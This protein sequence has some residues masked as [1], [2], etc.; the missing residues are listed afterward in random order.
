MS[1]GR[2]G[3]DEYGAR[4]QRKDE[5]PPNKTIKNYFSPVSKVID[6]SSPR[7]S[8]I[9]DYFIRSS[10]VIEKGSSPERTPRTDPNPQLPPTPL[11]T[12]SRASGRINKQAKRTQLIKKLNN[13]VTKAESDGDNPPG[14]AGFMGSDTAALLAEICSKA[15]D[16][17]DEAESQQSQAASNTGLSEGN[18]KRKHGAHPAKAAAEPSLHC[19][20]VL[21]DSTMNNSSIELHTDNTSSPSTISFEDFVRSQAEKDSVLS[22]SHGTSI[23]NT[24]LPQQTSPKTMTIQAQVHL[25]SLLASPT[26]VPAKIASIFCKKKMAEEQKKAD[27]TG[28]S[29]HVIQKR[30]SNVVIE[31]EDLELAVIDIEAIEPTKQKSTAAERQQF[32]KAFRQAGENPKNLAKKCAGKKKDLNTNTTEGTDD[33]KIQESGEKSPDKDGED[34][35]PAENKP[36]ES[37]KGQKLK[38]EL[39]KTKKIHSEKRLPVTER[40]AKP[41]SLEETSQPPQQSPVLRRSLR[42]HR[43][44]TTSGS[45]VPTTHESP[46]LMSTPKI[47]TPSRKNDIYKAEV[48]TVSSDLESPIRMRFT[49]LRR[50]ISDRQNA[51]ISDDEAFT[52][53]RKKVSSNNKKIDKA[54]QI[55]EKAKAIQ[56][57]IVKAET[58]QRRSAR[59]QKRLSQ[60]S[61]TKAPK[62]TPICQ[63]SKQPKQKNKAN[64]RSLND[65]LGKKE[66]AKISASSVLSL[67]TSEQ[68]SLRLTFMSLIIY[69]SSEASENSQDDE[70]FKAKREFLRSGLPDS[71]K[72]NIAKVAALKEAYALSSMSFHSVVHVQQKDGCEKWHM[73]MPH[74]PLLVKLVPVSL[75][76]PDVTSFTLSIGDFTSCSVPVTLQHFPGMLTRKA[77]F[78]EAVRNC[79]LEEIRWYNPQFPV[80]RFFTQFLKK[81]KDYLALQDNKPGGQQP[82]RNLRNKTAEEADNLAKRKRKD[83]PGLKSKKRKSDPTKDEPDEESAGKTRKQRL[84]RGSLRRS[85]PSRDPDVIVIEEEETPGPDAEGP[86]CEDVLWTE[87]YQPQSSSELIGNYVAIRSLHSW[88]RDW[89]ARAE[90]EERRT[91]KM[92]KDKNDTWDTDDFNEEDSDEDSLCNTMLI[93][94][95][96]GVGK[97]AAVYA[98]A[99]ELGFKVFEVNASC[100]RN[101]RQILAQL[102]EATQSHQVDQ[103]GVNAHKPCFFSSYSLGK[104]PRK[105]HSPKAVVS[106]PR[107]PPM[108]PRGGKKGLAPKS[109]A[110]FFKAAP[111]QKSEEKKTSLGHGKEKGTD[112]TQRKSATSLILFE[113]VDV[114]FDEDS[115]FLSAIKTFMS[116][117]KRPVILTT[118]DAM[119]GSMF[120]GVFEEITFHVP[121]VVN[122]ASYLQVLCLAENL[123][124]DTKDLMTFLTANTCDIRQSLLQLQFWAR[125]GGGGLKEKEL[126]PPAGK[127]GTLTSAAEED[128]GKSSIDVT[129]EMHPKELPECNFGCAENL[130]GLSSLVPPTEGLV[131]F[132][133]GRISKPE[134]LGRIMQ[135]LSEF[136]TRNQDL[137]FCNLENLLPL[138]LH[139]KESQAPVYESTEPAPSMEEEDVKM[140]AQMK[141]R[142]KLLLLND[143]DLFDSDSRSLDE[144]VFNKV[145]VDEPVDENQSYTHENPGKAVSHS[146]PLRR[147]LAGAELMASCL[148]YTC[149]DSMATF[150]DNLSYLDCCTC[151]AAEQAYAYNMN[152]TESRLRHGLCDSLRIDTA[153]PMIV[154]TAGEI[155]AYIEGLAFHKCSSALTKTLDTSLEQCRQ[156]GHDPTEQLTLQVSKSRQ[157]VNFSQ[158]STATATAEKRLSV[159][160]TVLSNRAFITLGNRQVNVTEYL[161][162]LRSI[163]RIEKAKEEGKTKRRFLHYLEGIH[164]E[165]PKTTV[166]SLATDFP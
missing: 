31:E 103:Q 21:S 83:S 78:S 42:R 57:N 163:C 146:V 115:G 97:T 139:V 145:T 151:E 4:R 41:Q 127:H 52:P 74:C 86:V 141:R 162:A 114:I 59:Q 85:G 99:Q 13:V 17:E 117:T 128:P 28:N 144:N 15:E 121:S 125:S 61:T 46:P 149:L 92:E 87:K 72:R 152:W 5:E 159:V 65:V 26:K 76:V 107:K 51:S 153:D 62:K 66:K 71:L 154:Q 164:L 126:S 53:G 148:V 77:I 12:S 137:L 36:S 155:R 100:Q 63:S 94:G 122:V 30:K 80:R 44:Q 6:K 119:F 150:A 136:Q 111:K 69:F 79:L 40:K 142:K 45:P 158:T 124:M 160:R 106:S 58:S 105:L 156:A 130:M 14:K 48:L 166:N 38:R 131:P 25:S 1:T 138:P 11:S 102:K 50:R 96:P 133:K 90:R 8:N 98:C 24:D 84:S 134:E 37:V 55:L 2:A 16:L 3:V 143:S 93:S 56:Q 161:P 60:D 101:G 118:S 89:K 7:P 109:L 120:D 39:K 43:A 67:Q 33:G 54:K 112:E 82:D 91:Q 147:K 81:Q 104:S 23:E 32:M 88:L 132:V 47:K 22:G 27:Q 129:L 68:K 34:D 29:D 64:L 116:T 165:L 70:H 19:N 135:L 35:N 49:R 18:L 73:V 75:D 157:E 108:S 9:A 20:N 113:E 140:S 10:P 123:R 110:N 95:P